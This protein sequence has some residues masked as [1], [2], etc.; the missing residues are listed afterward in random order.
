MLSAQEGE[1]HF[2]QRPQWEGATGTGLNRRCPQTASWLS[3]VRNWLLTDETI[4]SALKTLTG[5]VE[6]GVR[7]FKLKVPVRLGLQFLFSQ[8]TYFNYWA[9]G[10]S[11]CMLVNAKRKKNTVEA[12]GLEGV[13]QS[14]EER[15]EDRETNTEE[16]R[17][18]ILSLLQAE[19]V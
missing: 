11:V 18:H 13:E 12:A 8:L 10:L 4:K 3:W 14:S 5:G 19:W 2:L 6:P 16:G 1:E 9:R 7:P 17:R 15:W